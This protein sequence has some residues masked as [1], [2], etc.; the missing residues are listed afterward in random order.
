MRRRDWIAWVVIGIVLL[1]AGVA[2]ARNFACVE[3]PV[4]GSTES[5]VVNTLPFSAPWVATVAQLGCVDPNTSATIHTYGACLDSADPCHRGAG[6]PLPGATP[7]VNLTTHVT[8]AGP[9]DAISVLPVAVPSPAA[10][11]C[12]GG[13]NDAAACASASVCPSGA[14]GPCRAFV[15]FCGIA[16]GYTQ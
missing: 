1:A 10:L 8:G 4:T 7:T 12:V 11:A 16:P 6:I 5:A 2:H 9:I 15:S 13:A 3:F 14:C